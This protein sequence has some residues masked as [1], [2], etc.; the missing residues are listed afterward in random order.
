MTEPEQF[1]PEIVATL[2]AIDATLAGEAVDPRHADVA[3]LA[4]LLAA[5]RPRPDTAFAAGLDERVDRRF[6]AAPRVH[7]RRL[8]WSV[9]LPSAA[10]AV[11]LLVAVVIVAGQ[12]GGGSSS[13]FSGPA[14]PFAA[15]A[16]TLAAPHHHAAA[17]RAPLYKQTVTPHRTS[18]AASTAQGPAGPPTPG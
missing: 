2:E 5:E 6:E 14:A 1:D 7:R 3:E 18:A 17:S 4:L 11:S 12:G 9:W 13:S 16:R 8:A 10:V 15:G